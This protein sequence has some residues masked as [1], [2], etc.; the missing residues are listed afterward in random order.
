[1]CVSLSVLFDFISVTETVWI[2][3]EY[4]LAPEYK[5]PVWLDDASEVTQYIIENKQSF[6]ISLH[7]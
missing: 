7:R 1:M 2:L 4:R 3:V 6:G 5:F